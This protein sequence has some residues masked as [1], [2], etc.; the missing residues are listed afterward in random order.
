MYQFVM[1][2]IISVVLLVVIFLS[3]SDQAP[4]KKYPKEK[5]KVIVSF[6]E[7]MESVDY[8]QNDALFDG[9]ELNDDSFGGDGQ[10][11]EP[12]D[13]NDQNDELLDSNDQNDEPS[14]P[15]RQNDER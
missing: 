10:N 7:P 1:S 9:D 14:D 6:D 3:F 8:E 4:R 2:R 11:D 5:G 12:F 13:S 15:N